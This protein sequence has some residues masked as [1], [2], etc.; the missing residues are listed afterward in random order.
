MKKL[1]LVCLIEAAIAGYSAGALADIQDDFIMEN[2]SG[3]T[4]KDNQHLYVNPN[5]T[6]TDFIIENGGQLS[7]NE[8]SILNGAVIKSGGEIHFSQDTRSTG[9]LVI[10]KGA[11]A[12]ANNTN[13]FEIDVTTNN[14][15]VPGNVIF[16]TVDNAGL[17]EIGPTWTGG[18][19]VEDFAPI[20]D[21]PGADLVTTINTLNMKGG[22]VAMEA[23][24]PAAQ[25]NHLK[26]GTLTGQGDFYISTQMADGWGDHITVSNKATGNFGIEFAD[27]GKEPKSATR[28][29][30]VSVNSGDAA[31]RLLN[32]DETAEIG[33]YQY[34]LK[35]TQSG[36]STEW[37]LQGKRKGDKDTDNG[38]NGSDNGDTKPVLSYSAKNV[39][40]M[41]AAPRQVLQAESVS[42]QQ[43]PGNYYSNPQH[44]YGLWTRYLH[45]NTR[46][47]DKN[48]T[49]F[50]N[51]LDG[52]QIGVDKPFRLEDS[53]VLVGV[54]TGFSRSKV[55]TSDYGNGTV[56]SWHGGLYATWQHDN[57]FY[58]DAMLK[59]N[60]LD[61]TNNGRM[62]NGSAARGNY[63]QNAFT[64]SV[65][66]GFSYEIMPAL[67][68]QPYG[69]L[70]YARIGS[71]DY[72]L[73]NGMRADI[74]SADSFQGE[75]GTLVST[76]FEVRS[77]VLKPYVRLAVVHEFTKEND[78]TINR[79]NTFSND[80]SG[81][82]GK[83][84]LGLDAQITPQAAFYT[85]INYLNG[86]K[87]ETPV[88]A[89]LGFRV[90]F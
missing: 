64:A 22:M 44:S 34:S 11:E 15:A 54:F 19:N 50:K 43:R 31:F 86:N 20:P 16:E 56:E 51:K 29:T 77:A 60:R 17:L 26:I 7:L 5:I 36:N 45:D 87:R 83:Y 40:A 8:A 78:V 47:N 9:T 84:G 18:A 72:E 85:E 37:Y 67:T 1:V 14:P 82:T 23:Y 74:H 48:D 12:F 89:D 62:K 71:A 33:A 10:E 38:N 39:M 13:E 27:S 68:V 41:A 76:S 80:F 58:A 70:Q 4:V 88:S 24:S 90:R 79:T 35:K 49:A 73:S 25:Q 63:H 81:S 6:A 59:G 57:G 30:V 21:K 46:L 3:V 66:S 52:M 2:T 53:T 65:E 32:K 42:L 55:S 28:H 75:A 69:K 61:N